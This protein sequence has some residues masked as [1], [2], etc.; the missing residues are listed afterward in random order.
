MPSRHLPDLLP[1]ERPCHE[2]SSITERSFPSP[3][4]KPTSRLPAVHQTLRSHAGSNPIQKYASDATNPGPLRAPQKRSLQQPRLPTATSLRH[5]LGRLPRH[6][7]PTTALLT[8]KLAHAYQ[9]F[10]RSL[11]HIDYK[12]IQHSN[13]GN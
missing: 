12:R 9:Q 13:L 5:Q 6:L 8:L 10:G 3:P 11:S 2:K 1:T 4:P 7:R